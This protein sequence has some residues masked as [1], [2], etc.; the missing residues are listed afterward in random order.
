MGTATTTRKQATLK[1]STVKI[2]SKLKFELATLARDNKTLRS[3]AAET[4]GRANKV[5]D[6]L[7]PIVR[8]MVSDNSSFSCALF[9]ESWNRIEPHA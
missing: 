7:A 5:Y 4:I 3:S 1:R 6:Q 9:S 2:L 8:R